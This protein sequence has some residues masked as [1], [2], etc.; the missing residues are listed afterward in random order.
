MP[1]AFTPTS[2]SALT[3]PIPTGSGFGTRTQATRWRYDSAGASTTR[4]TQPEER[5]APNAQAASPAPNTAAGPPGSSESPR[6]ARLDLL[7]APPIHTER[8][9]KPACARLK[10]PAEVAC[11]T[12]HNNGSAAASTGTAD[13]DH[14]FS[15]CQ[16]ATA[17]C[18][19]RKCKVFKGVALNTCALGAGCGLVAD[20][21]VGIVGP[22]IGEWFLPRFNFLLGL[23]VNGAVGQSCCR[24]FCGRLAPAYGVRVGR[25]RLHFTKTGVRPLHRRIAI[26]SSRGSLQR[27]ERPSAAG[28]PTGSG[29]G[30]LHAAHALFGSPFPS[31]GYEWTTESRPI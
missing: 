1:P 26:E 12:L 3:P 16:R 10:G 15:H 4:F 18:A 21:C 25:R 31:I 14:F 11:R 5:C 17:I 2:S 22:K 7:T 8:S 28:I 9:A 6:T 19:K 23:A 20:G 30:R 27:V 13:G 29:R 24:F